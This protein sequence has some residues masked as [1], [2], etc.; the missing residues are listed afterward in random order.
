MG[1]R[2]VGDRAVGNGKKGDIEGREKWGTGQRKGRWVQGSE[3]TTEVK[4]EGGLVAS[5]GRAKAGGGG[6]AQKAGKPDCLGCGW[7]NSSESFCEK[8]R[9][10]RE[11]TPIGSGK[12][13][14]FPHYDSKA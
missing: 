9:G 11:Q 4:K 10:Q 1:E 6:R 12:G 13:S 2:E 5:R 8:T 14:S 3:I 7:G